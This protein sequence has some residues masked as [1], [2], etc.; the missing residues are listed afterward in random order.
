MKGKRRRPEGSILGTYFL[1]INKKRKKRDGGFEI[2]T[3]NALLLKQKKIA[4]E[5]PSWGLQP[6]SQSFALE[7]K[8][9]QTPTS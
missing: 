6:K 1:I 5:N 7:N 9:C 4:S 8:T 2:K 3:K